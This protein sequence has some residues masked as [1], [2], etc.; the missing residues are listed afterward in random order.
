MKN[1]LGIEAFAANIGL[2]TLGI[3]PPRQPVQAADA[4]I[5]DRRFEVSSGEFVKRVLAQSRASGPYPL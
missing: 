2:E 5:R 3:R 4:V 1:I